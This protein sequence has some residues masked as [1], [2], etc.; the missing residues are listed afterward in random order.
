MPVEQGKQ[1]SA[2]T[3]RAGGRTSA[4]AIVQRLDGFS[5]P[6]L[7]EAIDLPRG[8]SFDPVLV[9]RGRTTVPVVFTAAADATFEVGAVRLVGRSISGDRKEALDYGLGPRRLVPEATHA[10]LGGT[11]VWPQN[12]NIQP[13]IREVRVTR[14]LIVAIRQGA[15]FEL[16]AR[17]ANAVVGPG[18]SIELTV[19]VVRR[20]GFT[21]AVAVSTSDLP[22]NMPSASA[23]IG[24]E[25][26]S[27]VIKLTV[28]AN[29]PPGGY[30]FIVRGTGS[31][32]FNKDP[33]AKEKPNIGVNEPSNPIRLTVRRP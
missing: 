18:E 10:A 11:L 31:F 12:P 4:L 1:P 6:V 30:S 24:K 8:V 33:N 32:P 20:A 26:T 22:P 7:I 2:L 27:A 9:G 14:G 17:P 19:D 29:V 23:T 16:T 3:L 28:P 21:E 13:S 15:P 5:G 25:A